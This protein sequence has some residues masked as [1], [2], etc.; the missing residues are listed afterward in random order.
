MLNRNDLLRIGKLLANLVLDYLRWTQ[1]IPMVLCWAFACVMI[2]GLLLVGFHEATQAHPDRFGEGLEQAGP[3]L[4]PV[5]DAVGP[6]V[7][8]MA[9][10][11]EGLTVEQGVIRIWG[12][13]ALIGMLL[14]WLRTAV[15]G[16]PNPWPLRRKIGVAAF[17]AV[18]YGLLL[19]GAIVFFSAEASTLAIVANAVAFPLVLVGISAWGLAV[20]Q[21]IY[22]LQ[23]E[24]VD[25]NGEI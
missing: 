9:D 14:S 20:S 10:S 2:G 11:G 22:T 21:L 19:S 25:A 7:S 18:A 3:V 16:P 24:L 17:T 13:L 1:L 23:R 12:W 6:V 5:L 8:F 4:G 15:W